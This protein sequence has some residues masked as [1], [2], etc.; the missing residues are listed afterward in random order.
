MSN[1][2][3]QN[4]LQQ[5]VVIMGFHTHQFN[6]DNVFLKIH[7]CMFMLAASTLTWSPRR[8]F[9]PLF[10]SPRELVELLP[11]HSVMGEIS[12]IKTLEHQMLEDQSELFFILSHLGLS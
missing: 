7:M 11:C 6:I 12:T 4:L 10:A 1:T 2:Q 3:W 9:I 5:D 8:L